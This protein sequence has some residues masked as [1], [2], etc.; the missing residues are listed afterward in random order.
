[1]NTS[2]ILHNKVC[3][4]GKLNKIAKRL[5]NLA[6]GEFA[7]L[8]TFVFV[9][10]SLNLGMASLIAF[11]YLIIILLQGSMY[12]FYRYILLIK[13]ESLSLNAIKI[14]SVLRHL[15]MVL[16]VATSMIIPIIKSNN[17]DLLIAIG[18]LLFGIVEYINYYW[19]RLS[20]GKSGFNIR[21]LLNTKLQKSSINKL[22]SK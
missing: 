7:A 5:L 6:I 14:L 13:R 17:K 11:S 18:L 12:W 19:Y 20:Y 22:I 21:I 3:R 9:F 8:C 1:M 16:V 4:G 15:N 2:R 10:R